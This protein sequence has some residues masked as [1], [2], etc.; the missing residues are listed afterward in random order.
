MASI[1]SAQRL[2]NRGWLKSGFNPSIENDARGL[3]PLWHSWQCAF[4]NGMTFCSKNSG[5]AARAV[6]AGKH[7]TMPKARRA[8]KTMVF[9]AVFEMVFIDLLPNRL[10]VG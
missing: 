1:T 10:P 9:I 3:L 2:A 6:E 7:S 4:T 8:Q 5:P